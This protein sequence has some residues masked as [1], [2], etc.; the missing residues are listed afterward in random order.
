MQWLTFGLMSFVGWGYAARIHARNRDM[1]ELAGGAPME[2][3]T[4]QVARQERIR[5]AK[6]LRRK[7]KGRYSDEDAEDAW[8]EDRL[9]RE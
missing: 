1:E 9:R 6:R 7:R 5:E 4:S 8:V 3:G 2:A